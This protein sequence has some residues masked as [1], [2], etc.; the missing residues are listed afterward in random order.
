MNLKILNTNLLNDFPRSL[1]HRVHMITCHSLLFGTLTLKFQ[2]IG[3]T[4]FFRKTK[5][6]IQGASENLNEPS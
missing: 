5:E 2:N 1:N 3:L 6:P 4:S